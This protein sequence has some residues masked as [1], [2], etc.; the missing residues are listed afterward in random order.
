MEKRRTA[1]GRALSPAFCRH[2]L[3]HLLKPSASLPGKGPPRPRARG[4]QASSPTIFRRAGSA[5]SRTGGTVWRQ[6]AGQ[7][8]PHPLAQG[9]PWHRRENAAACLGVMTRFVGRAL[10]DVPQARGHRRYAE[11]KEHKIHTGLPTLM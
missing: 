11:K 1:K 5:S 2:L 3:R 8:A 7:S 10:L 9:N 4:E 6:R